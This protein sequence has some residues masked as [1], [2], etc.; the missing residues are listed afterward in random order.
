MRVHHVE[1][2]AAQQLD[3]ASKAV[4]V[5]LRAPAEH[6]VRDACRRHLRCERAAV[7]LPRRAKPGVNPLAVQLQGE[8]DRESLGAPV[9]GHAVDDRQNPWLRAC[10]T[11][12]S[13]R[14][15]GVRQLRLHHRRIIAPTRPRTDLSLG[16]DG[17]LI[18]MHCHVLAG[19]DDGPES[20]EGSLALARAAVATGTRTLLATPHVNHRYPNDPDTIAR[21]VG[22]LNERLAAEGIALDVRAGAEIAMTRVGDIEPAQLSRLSLGG[23]EWL[24]VEPPFTSAS[25]GI[26]EILVEL[27]ERG[28][29]VLLAHPER[30]QAFHRDPDLLEEIVAGGVLTSITAD[31]LVGKFGD[32]VRSFA[33]GLIHKGI[34]H[35]VASDAHD[36]LK[37]PPGA[38]AQ[39]QQSGLG[40]LAGWLTEEVPGAILSGS[41]IPPR[42]DVHLPRSRAPHRWRL[43]RQ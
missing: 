40:E 2:L 25:G 36:H 29:R 38:I 34:V 35:N 42:P 11:C 6:G 33:L 43:K 26:A 13:D 30:C 41:A 19:I 24:L 22:E 8:P 28:H 27:Q 21:L 14:N 7:A 4:D 31:S 32:T 3:Q 9:I 37:R 16:L 39:L 12:S 10:P 5:P 23:G 20:I 15:V 17:L 18:D 1:A